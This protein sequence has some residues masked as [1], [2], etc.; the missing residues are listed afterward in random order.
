MIVED[1]QLQN[2]RSR[3]LE[4]CR[5]RLR[6]ELPCRK[7]VGNDITLLGKEGKVIARDFL[8][9]L[10]ISGVKPTISVALWS[11]GG[12]G[13]FGIYAHGITETWVLEKVWLHVRQRGTQL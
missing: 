3:I 9:R 5:A 11:E 1:K 10:I 8:V 6:Y 13:L 12:M 4:L 2:L 7:T